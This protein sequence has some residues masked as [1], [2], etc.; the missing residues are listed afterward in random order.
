MLVTV[1][2]HCGSAPRAYAHVFNAQKLLWVKPSITLS[3]RLGLVGLATGT[4]G[5]CAIVA[6]ADVG[7]ASIPNRTKSSITRRTQRRIMRDTSGTT[8]G[9][10]SITRADVIITSAIRSHVPCPSARD[11]ELFVVVRTV[12]S[13]RSLPVGTC[14]DVNLTRA[15]HQMVPSVAT[16]ALLHVGVGAIRAERWGPV[17]ARADLLLADVVDHGVPI[18]GTRTA[19]LCPGRRATRATVGGAELT[20]ALPPF[21]TLNTIQI[22]TSTA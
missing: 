2:A 8:G 5:R 20:D 13:F 17:V 16:L 6:G 18:D 4:S 19:A 9:L 3:A 14:A 15:A 12:R 11:T 7:N 22:V 1:W 10:A 21:E